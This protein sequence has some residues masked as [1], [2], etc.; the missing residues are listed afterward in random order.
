MEKE[1][2][3]VRITLLNKEEIFNILEEF[4]PTSNKFYELIKKQELIKIILEQ[5]IPCFCFEPRNIG[6]MSNVDIV[7]DDLGRLVFELNTSSSEIFDVIMFNPN[8]PIYKEEF[9]YRYLKSDE[10]VKGTLTFTMDKT[11]ENIYTSEAL[12]AKRHREKKLKGEKLKKQKKLEQVRSRIKAI[13]REKKR[14][15]EGVIK[16]YK[17][18]VC[19][20]KTDSVCKNDYPKILKKVLED[21]G[22]NI[23]WE[24]S[25]N[26][27]R[28]RELWRKYEDNITFKLTPENMD[29]DIEKILG[30]HSIDIQTET[31]SGQLNVNI[32]EVTEKYKIIFGKSN[33]IQEHV[34]TGD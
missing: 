26:I 12:T 7:Q 5:V 8:Y 33:E 32:F 23:D 9:V 1:V 10:F 2:Y 15:P 20:V 29:K 19:E 25:K 17:H 14:K 6:S 30:N 4:D 13:K 22:L 18:L 3:V 11:V 16:D 34:L 28:K 31:E 21:S 27:W 24:D